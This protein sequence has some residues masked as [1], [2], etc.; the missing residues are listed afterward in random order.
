MKCTTYEQLH[1]EMARVYKMCVGTKFE[2]KEHLCVKLD[3]IICPMLP[4]LTGEPSR[5]EFVLGIVEDRRVW[6]RDDIFFCGKPVK[7]HRGS[8]F[9]PDCAFRWS[10][11]PPA[12]PKPVLTREELEASIA[13]LQKE[14]LEIW[15]KKPKTV[16]I[17]VNGGEAITLRLPD[18]DNPACDFAICIT[19]YGGGVHSFYYKDNKDKNLMEKFLHDLLEGKL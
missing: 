19:A 3:G 10:W 14:L 18:G 15:D 13:K 11:I 8:I 1:L 12:P 4:I 2:G 16:S 6:E 17:S 9:S 7:A 5:Y